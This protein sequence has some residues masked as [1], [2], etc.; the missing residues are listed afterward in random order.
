[1]RLA[2]EAHAAGL[3]DWQLFLTPSWAGQV[4]RPERRER[5]LRGYLHQ[6][7]R[8]ARVPF[9]NLVWFCREEVGEA[10]G[11]PHFHLLIAGLPGWCLGFDFG[12]VVAQLW[13]HGWLDARLWVRGLGAV[14]YSSE[15]ET[16]GA[17]IYEGRKFRAGLPIILSESLS[18]VVDRGTG[19][20]V[21]SEDAK[22]SDNP[23]ESVH[24]VD[25]E[26]GL[27]QQQPER[28]PSLEHSSR[29]GHLAAV[30]VS[31]TAI[32]CTF[33]ADITGAL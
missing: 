2:P 21:G 7:A 29:R 33:L 25:L 14:N 18:R 10:F 16:D 23:R 31:R 22:H 6:V 5:L 9:G 20:N 12:V 15:E 13:P 26:T 27:D 19:D 24:G 3:V 4:P 11:R 1:M 17:N 28:A 8:R 30:N 32:Q